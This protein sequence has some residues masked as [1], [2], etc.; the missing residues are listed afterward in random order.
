MKNY[1]SDPMTR[2]LIVHD[3][4]SGEIRILEKI[5]KV[6]MF[7]VSEVKLGDFD[8]PNQGAPVDEYDDKGGY[9]NSILRRK[10][11]GS[12]RKPKSATVGRKKPVCKTCGGSLHGRGT[13]PMKA[14]QAPADVAAEI[15]SETPIEP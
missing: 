6:R 12:S 1:Y 11:V 15:R 9:E 3:T 8:G 2:N 10:A 4:E 14:T 13:C 7:T 5:E